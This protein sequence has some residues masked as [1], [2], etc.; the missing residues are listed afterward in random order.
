MDRNG[1]LDMLESRLL[2]ETNI[3]KVEMTRKWTADIPAEPGVYVFID[4][5]QVVYVGETG[6]LQGRMTDLLDSRHHT[7]RR[8]IGERFYITVQ[9]YA[10]ATTKIKFPQHIE[11]LVEEHLCTRLSLAYLPVEL[12]RK[13]LEEQIHDKIAVEVRLNKRGKRKSA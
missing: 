13:E 5:G 9:G 10:K 3:R 6:N 1:Y 12:G 2:E 4:A 7:V 11:I 8:T